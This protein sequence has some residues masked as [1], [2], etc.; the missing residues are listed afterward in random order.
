MA[1]SDIDARFE[2]DP[3]E[4]MKTHTV[5]PQDYKDRGT[6]STT[7]LYDRTP[8]SYNKP[9]AVLAPRDSTLALTGADNQ[10]AFTKLS[11]TDNQYGESKNQYNL[12]FYSK[13]VAGL[14][15][16]DDYMASYFLPWTSDHLTRIV[17]PPK[18][19]ARDG[20]SLAAQ[21]QRDPDLFFTAAVNGCSVFVEDDPRHPTVYHAGTTES[22]SDLSNANPFLA[23]NARL[24][25]TRLFEQLWRPVTDGNG[26][27]R[28]ASSPKVNVGRDAAAM[29][30][31]WPVVYFR[32]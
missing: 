22:R 17:I 5:Q 4:F 28:K 20:V 2:R 32:E 23:G 11:R 12:F 3:L 19:P 15:S 13:A 9:G 21:R 1:K 25:W 27:M 30:V 31:G 24:H 16:M 7:A 6:Q 8:H 14:S 10:V 29:R 26:S 18:I